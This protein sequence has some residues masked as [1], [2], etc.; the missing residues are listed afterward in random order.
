MEPPTRR[1]DPK[2]A[3]RCGRCDGGCRAAGA[4]PDPRAC[5]GR[6]RR[7]DALEG[8]AWPG[9]SRCRAEPRCGVTTHRGPRLP[10]PAR[11]DRRAAPR[12][13]AGASPRRNPLVADVGPNRLDSVSRVPGFRHA[14]RERDECAAS[15]RSLVESERPL[16]GD[17][18][19][20]PRDVGTHA[21]CVRSMPLNRL[22]EGARP[23]TEFRRA[24]HG[25]NHRG[26][27]GE[28]P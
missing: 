21:C 22:L 20:C 18:R 28:E 25:F 10:R 19:Y 1:P 2:C 13:P 26:T 11:S 27:R 17:L 8:I 5:A 7:V 3:T 16:P 4:R 12:L 23:V 9:R 6:R 15:V 14:R 24:G